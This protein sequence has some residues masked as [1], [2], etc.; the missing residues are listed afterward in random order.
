MSKYL[1]YYHQDSGHANKVAMFFALTD[2]PVEKKWV[3]IHQARDKRP[4]EFQN[5]AKFGEVPTLIHEGKSVVQSNNILLYLAE[6]TGLLGP[7]GSV[8]WADIRTWL[9]WEANRLGLALP[10]LRFAYRFDPSTPKGAIEWLEKRI[11]IDLS[12]LEKEFSDGRPF[13]LGDKIT[14]ADLSLAGYIFW[15]EEG[16]VQLE[17]WPRVLAWRESFKDLKG[18]KT[19]YDLMPRGEK[20]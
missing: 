8:A 1:L 4:I 10:N 3:D 7:Y 16:R 18:W 13:I 15:A 14:I 17:K 20:A 12:R 5:V 19:P 2:T 11:D 6:Q 9:F